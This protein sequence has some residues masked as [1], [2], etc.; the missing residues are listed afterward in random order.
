[1]PCGPAG[2][3]DESQA[4]IQVMGCTVLRT[5]LEP[6]G[7][8][9]PTTASQVES[10][11]GQRTGDAAAAIRFINRHVGKQ[12]NALPFSMQWDHAQVTHHVAI[13]FPDISRKRQRNV[14]GD[15]GCPTQEA[16]VAR[17]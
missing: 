11:Q 12:I 9:T 4:V 3:L 2:A 8:D 10:L 16:R 17:Y 15:R 5:H 1:M 14:L 13:L 6:H 7:A